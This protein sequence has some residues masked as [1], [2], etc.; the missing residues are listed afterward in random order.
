MV[1]SCMDLPST[2]QVAKTQP[3]RDKSFSFIFHRLKPLICCLMSFCGLIKGIS[4]KICILCVRVKINKRS[5]EPFCV[6]ILSPELVYKTHIHRD[7]PEDLFGASFVQLQIG[8]V[9]FSISDSYTMAC[10]FSRGPREC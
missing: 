1:P 6:W 5:F 7:R 9:D 4:P 8:S 3:K 10:T 2:E